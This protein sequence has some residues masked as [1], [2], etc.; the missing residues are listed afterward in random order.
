MQHT[1][2]LP[3]RRRAT[4]AHCWTTFSVEDVLWIASHS[5]LLGDP[6]LGPDQPQRFLPSRFNVEGNALDIRGFV[7]RSLACPK[8]HL[9]LA[10][11]L[12]EM[13]PFFV[14]ILGTPACGKSY[15][16]AALTW[17]LR[18]LLPLHFG[19][20]FLETDT[21]ANRNLSEYEEA[22]FH[23]PRADELVPLADL[24]R[25]TE[26]QGDLY[27]TVMQGNQA[28]NYPRPFLFTL[29]LQDQHPNAR[30]ARHIGRVCCLYDNAGEHFLAG[31]DTVSSP[32]TQHLA[33]A[34][35]LMYLF[36]P[37]QD[38]RFRQLCQANGLAVDDPSLAPARTARQENV[39]HEAANRI[40]RYTGLPQ[41]AR[42][43]KPLIVAVTKWDVWVALLQ[44]KNVQ[45]PWAA[46]GKVS[47]L[48]IVR[49]ERRSQE[50]RQLLLRTTPEIV[51][52]AE[53][54]AQHVVY[55]PVS[56]LG[57]RPE[58]DPRTRKLAIRPRQI[59]PLWVTVPFIY[60]LYKALPGLVSAAP[61]TQ[62]RGV[63]GAR[64]GSTAPPPSRGG[65]LP[66][67]MK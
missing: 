22:L 31:Q 46:G 40:R 14:S 8:C 50:V 24:I 61:G 5:D 23:N 42:H 29:Q 12:V 48:D 67:W 62:V 57:R 63:P 56:A 11:A 20:S 53:S 33:R 49:V 47:A 7:C 26:L 44:D 51:S 10:R 36:D 1:R 65:S 15:Y 39:L 30:N 19:L 32:V 35:V 9:P 34:G 25:K 4:C 64:S 37:T 41:T 13:E 58:V 66:P 2:E 45:D 27:H 17:E 28:I 52:A 3:L 43:N 55:L 59:R 6:K 38:Q 18:R 60:G 54:F 16:L 21:L